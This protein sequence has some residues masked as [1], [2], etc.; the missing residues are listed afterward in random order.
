MS[1]VVVTGSCGLVGSESAAH[2]ATL[3]YDVVGIDNDLRSAFFGPDASTTRVRARLLHD[4]PRYRHR[5]VDVRDRQ[6]L[7]GVFAAHGRD[8][9]LVI[10][11]AAQPSHDWAATDP[12]TDFSVNATG[13]LN[14]LECARQAC[15]EAPFIFTST[16]KVYGDAP[17]RLPFVEL[18]RR[19]D[20]PADHPLYDGIDE[21]MSIDA[22]IHSLFGVSKA[23]ADLL[24]QEYGRYFGMKT[25]C[26]R[27]G[28][29]T[30]PNHAGVMLHGFLAYLMKCVC[31]ATP[32]T[33]FGYQG[34][35]VRDNL[36]SADLVAAFDAVIAAPPVGEVYNIGGGRFANCSV[37]EAIAMAEEVAGRSLP[38][39]YDPRPR[40]GDHIWY[41]S[42][43]ARF[44]QHHPA[45]RPQVTVRRALEEI[46]EFNTS[47]WTE[48]AGPA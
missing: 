24:V 44:Q 23:S 40:V 31:T 5:D 18:E 7:D 26:F 20:L 48:D 11:T 17:N 4:H 28:C 41:V 37:L 6:A 27:A 42:N 38:V 14:V 39:T 43:L 3:G 15:P 32:Y 8:I 46:Y 33:I 25:V 30:G 34:K 1:V 13:T 36:H 47:R 12:A 10:H 29:L 16:N 9:A 21:S 19:W 2:Y 35:Q 45:W 22:S